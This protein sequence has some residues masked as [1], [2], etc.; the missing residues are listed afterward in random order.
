M[1]LPLPTIDVPT[2]ELELPSNGKKIKFRPFLTKEEKILL[3]ALESKEESDMISAVRQIVQNCII[4]AYPGFDVSDLPWFDL[5]YFFLNLRA[6]SM[7]EK[8]EPKFQCNSL[9]AAGNVCGN[10]ITTEI[11]LLAV[12]VEKVPEHSTKILLAGNVG[13]K[14]KYPNFDSIAALRQ[15]KEGNATEATEDMIIDHIDY[16]Y[17]GDTVFPVKE[18]SRD[19][20]KEWL[21]KLTQTQFDKISN[22]FTE[23]PKVKIKK[24][25]KCSKCGF[26]HVIPFEG[27]A[28]FFG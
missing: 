5:E 18:Q 7:G 9:D 27:I 24:E 23:M 20:L 14:M 11:D 1:T 3:M 21:E 15:F 17:M 26:D 8:V 22:F 4:S 12:K 13:V 10:I 16:I 28:S 19:D 2:Y 25:V 6:R